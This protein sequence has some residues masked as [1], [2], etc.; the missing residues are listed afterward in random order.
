MTPAAGRVPLELV[1]V[2]AA[3]VT[4]AGA[5]VLVLGVLAAA[6]SPRRA[7]E[8]FAVH[9]AFALELFLAAGLIRLAALD[10]LRALAT[11]A[12][13]VAVRQVLARGVRAG[14]RATT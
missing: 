5:V 2:P 1:A 9:A 6:R 3:L 12:V 8:R 4:G 13:T 10:S 7:G 14:A 11:V